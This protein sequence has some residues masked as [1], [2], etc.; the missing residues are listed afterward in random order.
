MRQGFVITN[1]NDGTND[2]RSCIGWE[3]TSGNA[4]R[5]FMNANLHEFWATNGSGAARQICSMQA[6]SDTAQFNVRVGMLVSDFFRKG[7]SSGLTA[8]GVSQP[9]ALGLV[10][11]F[12]EVTTVAAGSGVRLPA[13]TTQSVTGL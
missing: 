12:N 4:L 13:G 1:H 5:M 6:M 7:A 8:A 2:E 3:D 9:G 11:N 10:Q